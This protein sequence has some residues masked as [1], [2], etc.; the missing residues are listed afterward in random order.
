MLKKILH[1]SKSAKVIFSNKENIH[2]YNWMGLTAIAK[3]NFPDRHR[4][5]LHIDRSAQLQIVGKKMSPLSKLLKFVNDEILLNTSFNVSV[6]TL[7]G[8]YLDCFV[9]MKR[10]NF[11]IRLPTMVYISE[12]K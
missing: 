3:E 5:C 1:F 11:F 4:S 8:D 6:D 10:M 12:R 7:V 2:N 9:N